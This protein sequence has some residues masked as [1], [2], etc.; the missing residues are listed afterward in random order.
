MMES[1]YVA[2]GASAIVVTTILELLKRSEKL[3][4]INRDSGKTNATLSAVA[5]LLTGIGLT[6]SFDFN[7]E[8]GHFHAEFS[9]NV[10]DILNMLGH[11]FWQWC[12]QHFTYQLAVKPGVLQERQLD[13]LRE[14]K[15]IQEQ[16][17]ARQKAMGGF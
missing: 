2:G 5:A 10:W 16:V 13:V 3:S 4:W 11:A 6:Y 17:A 15:Q 9:G 1:I 12:Q 7:P 14:I 8:S